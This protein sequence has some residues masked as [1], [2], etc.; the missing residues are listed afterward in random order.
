MNRTPYQ[1]DEVLME[2]LTADQLDAAA[3]LFQRYRVNLFNFFLRLGF[4]RAASEDMIQTVF[5]RV[6][7]YRKSFRHGLA[8]RTWLYQIARNVQADFQRQR[9][10]QR[11]EEIGAYENTAAFS[12][13]GTGAWLE[14]EENFVQMEKAMQQLPKDQLEILLMTRYQKMKYAEV[15]VLLGISEGAVKVKIFRA[16]QLLRTLYF[17]M[18]KK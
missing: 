2:Q 1:T 16:L 6:I 9:G 13:N 3:V 11:Q 17:K 8:F 4:D 15:G 10:Y 18:E 14:Q 5:E 7:K 12:E